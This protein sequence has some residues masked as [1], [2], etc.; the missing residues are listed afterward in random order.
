MMNMIFGFSPA[1]ADARCRKLPATA[2]ATPA[3]VNFKKSLRLMLENILLLL[4]RF[5]SLCTSATFPYLH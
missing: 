4:L 3:L 1:N 2:A 5:L